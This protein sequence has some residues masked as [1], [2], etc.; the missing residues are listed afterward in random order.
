MPV[1]EPRT[2]G[3]GH[4]GPTDTQRSGLLTRAAFRSH[5]VYSSALVPCEVDVAL[6]LAAPWSVIVDFPPSGQVALVLVSRGCSP[7]ASYGIPAV[8]DPSCGS[9]PAGDSVDRRGRLAGCT[10]LLRLLAAPGRSDQLSQ[11]SRRRR[12]ILH[13]HA[14]PGLDR[15]R[16]ACVTKTRMGATNR[17]RDRTRIPTAVRKGSRSGQRGCLMPESSRAGVVEVDLCA[18]KQ[19]YCVWGRDVAGAVGRGADP[20]VPDDG[21]VAVRAGG[22]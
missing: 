9:A 18:S 22:L 6:V 8:L 10:V 11:R 20:V 12:I 4:S 17:H 3:A 2:Q 13:R 16:T 14:R 1:E 5:F 7:Q 19:S 15:S 21:V